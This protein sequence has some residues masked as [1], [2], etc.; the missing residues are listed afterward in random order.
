MSNPLQNGA[1]TTDAAAATL[2]IHSGKDRNRT[3]VGLAIMQINP[4]S[5][6]GEH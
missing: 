2:T 5:M 1:T 3:R 4:R 6:S